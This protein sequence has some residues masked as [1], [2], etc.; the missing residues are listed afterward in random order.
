MSAASA[1]RQRLLSVVAP[2]WN[3]AEGVEELHRRISLV[4][5]ALAP[6]LD[7]EVVIGDD[8]SSDGTT[9]ILARLSLDD[10][11]LVVV[12]LSRNFGHQ[13]CILAA[14]SQ[15][16]GDLIVLMD[17]DLE[18]PPEEIPSLVA[19]H[20]QGAEIVLAVRAS[21]KDRFL[22][23]VL[24]REFHR[25]IGWL[26]DMP[27]PEN[28]GTFCLLSRRAAKV[29]LAMG[30]TNRFLPGL[31]SWAGFRTARV[32]YH[33]QGRFSG[34]PRQSMGRLFRYAFDAIFGFSYKPLRLSMYVGLLTWICSG[35]YAVALIATRLMQVNVVPGF[36]TTSVLVLFFGGMS[37]MSFGIL[38]EY[39]GRVYD[40]VKRR[41]LFVIDRVIRSGIA[42][43]FVEF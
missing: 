5:D 35:L 2:V 10:P 30:E 39:L 42:K 28:T 43:E 6:G 15:A 38:G 3:E 21:R 29:M 11:R 34:T 14:L 24:F 32:L 4:L 23:R 40:E 9:E 16:R 25:V 8:G 12:R 18:D 19:A 13:A 31:R 20:D 17:G 1:E 26:S 33:R 22:R 27:I 7:G 36:T 41:P 37:L